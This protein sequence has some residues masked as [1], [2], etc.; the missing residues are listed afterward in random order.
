MTINERVKK[1]RIELGMS[2]D[3]LAELLHKNRATIYRYESQEIDKFPLEIVEPLAK[4]LKTTPQY[5]MGWTDDF[6]A[7]KDKSNTPEYYYDK[8]TRDLADFLHKNPD[9]KVL[10]DAS[11]KVKPED[12][13]FVKTM[14]ERMGGNDGTD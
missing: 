11:R 3:D 10:F 5:L 12:I 2:V 6:E 13:E 1:R 4:A 14:I 9:Y 7:P 8:D